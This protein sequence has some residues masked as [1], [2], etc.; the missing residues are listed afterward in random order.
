MAD[1]GWMVDGGRRT[2]SCTLVVRAY[3]EMERVALE[4][5]SPKIAIHDLLCDL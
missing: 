3:T 5:D 1:I 4:Q 2:V